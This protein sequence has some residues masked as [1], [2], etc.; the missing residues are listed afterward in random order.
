[1]VCPPCDTGLTWSMSVPSPPHA[2]HALSRSLTARICALVI[3]AARFLY[4]RR[5]RCRFSW[6]AVVGFLGSD[7]TLSLIWMRRRSRSHIDWRDTPYFL[8]RA[9]QD[10]P[11]S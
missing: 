10:H 9:A 3:R 6:I 2:R 4:R 1:M 7:S 11:V 5:V 8:P